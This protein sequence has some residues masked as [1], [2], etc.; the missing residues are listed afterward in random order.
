MKIKFRYT[1]LLKKNPNLQ[2]YRIT[3]YRII[4]TQINQKALYLINI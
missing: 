1:N 3:K 2:N 4:K